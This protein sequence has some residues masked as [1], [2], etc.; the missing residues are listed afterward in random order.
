MAKSV[1]PA[2][3]DNADLVVDVLDMVLDRVLREE[4]LLGH[5]T[6]GEAARQEPQ[7]LD[8]PLAEAGRPLP[9]G[10]GDAV[11]SFSQHGTDG[12]TVQSAHSCLATQFLSRLLGGQRGTVGARLGHGLVGIGGGQDA[13]RGRETLARGGAVIARAVHPLVVS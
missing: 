1:A 5:V 11:P 3:V 12:V 9:P 13:R 4:E 10:S 2:R 7:H 6:V 8:L